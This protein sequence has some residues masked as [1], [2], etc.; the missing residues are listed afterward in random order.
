MKCPRGKTAKVRPLS[1][2]NPSITGCQTQWYRLI[3]GRKSCLQSKRLLER[4]LLEW[5]V[6]PTCE[7][8]HVDRYPRFEMWF[9]DEQRSW[10]FTAT[11]FVGGFAFITWKSN[12]TCGDH[13]TPHVREVDCQAQYIWMSTNFRRKTS[14]R[15]HFCQWESDLIKSFYLMEKH[16]KHRALMRTFLVGQIPKTHHG[17]QLERS[18]SA[19]FPSRHRRD[20]I[21]NS[22]CTSRCIM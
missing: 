3:S 16:Q 20:S 18:A 9:N 2:M 11:H 13:E 7:A 12:I 14:N 21:S 17:L 6:A 15:V 1:Q 19:R 8:G 10:C 4:Q 5:W 22:Q